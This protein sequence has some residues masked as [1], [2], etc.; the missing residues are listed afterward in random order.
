M[1]DAV[2]VN[3]NISSVSFQNASNGSDKVYVPVRPA[4]VVYSQLEH[5]SGVAAR[6]NQMGVTVSKVQILNSLIDQ[7]ISM[8]AFPNLDSSKEAPLNEK[9]I[10]VLIDSFQMKLQTTIQVAKATGYGLAGATP[11]VGVLFTLDA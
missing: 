6:E 8:R 7:L 4:N 10:D 9:Q 5:V 1:V 3:N 11:D 2:S